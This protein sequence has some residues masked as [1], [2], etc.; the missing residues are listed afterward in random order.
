MSNSALWDTTAHNRTLGL[1]NNKNK[2]KN[3]KN[4]KIWNY[5]DNDFCYYLY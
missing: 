2:N 5:I 4:E 1:D 3:K